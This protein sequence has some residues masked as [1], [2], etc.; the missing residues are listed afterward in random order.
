MNKQNDRDMCTTHNQ[1]KTLY[2]LEHKKS[3]CTACS[4]DHVYQDKCD[5]AKTFVACKKDILLFLTSSENFGNGINKKI[6]DTGSHLKEIFE[7]NESKESLVKTYKSIKKAMD[8]AEKAILYIGRKQAQV[9]EKANLH[10]AE[11]KLEE[12]HIMRKLKEYTELKKNFED[13]K[14]DGGKSSSKRTICEIFDTVPTLYNLNAEIAKWREKSTAQKKIRRLVKDVGEE[15]K[16]KKLKEIEEATTKYYETL[17]EICSEI[18]KIELEHKAF[19]KINTSNEE[20]K[21]PSTEV[22]GDYSTTIAYSQYIG[23]S[24]VP[25]NDSDSLNEGRVEE[26]YIQISSPDTLSILKEEDKESQMFVYVDWSERAIYAMNTKKQTSKKILIPEE[27]PSLAEYVQMSDKEFIFAGGEDKDNKKVANCFKF[28]ITDYSF[29]E[30]KQMNVPKSNHKL[31]KVDDK[32]YSLGGSTINDY[33]SVDLD[34][35]E[36]FDGKNWISGPDMCVKAQGLAAAYMNN[37]YTFGGRSESELITF[38]QILLHGQWSKINPSISEEVEWSIALPLNDSILLFAA[39]KEIW[40]FNT[41]TEGMAKK[42]DTIDE[43]CIDRSS[44]AVINGN[45]YIVGTDDKTL[46][47]LSNDEWEKVKKEKWMCHTA[48]PKRIKT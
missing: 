30:I 35:V 4:D 46:M 11:F 13:F 16:K 44:A 33:E 36:I 8:Y 38:I 15:S 40:E 29:T 18:P 17:K 47:I 1:R 23:S 14:E 22:A 45:V 37:L 3:M 12:T 5:N 32:V 48:T 39:E 19:S 42:E 34:I 26:S 9:L 27:V 20:F 25:S 6:K 24:I 41:N 43:G 21:T 7:N 28:N 10:H 31:V 2:C